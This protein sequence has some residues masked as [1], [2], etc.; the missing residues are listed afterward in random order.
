MAWSS[1]AFPSMLFVVHF[2]AAYDYDDHLLLPAPPLPAELE[3]LR[4]KAAAWTRVDHAGGRGAGMVG[5][6]KPP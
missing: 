2:G 4:A 5:A 3:P 6:E 1:A